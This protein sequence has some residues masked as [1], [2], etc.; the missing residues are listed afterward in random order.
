MGKKSR[1]GSGMNIPNHI[2]KSL[3]TIFGLKIL[4]FFDADPDPGWKNSD[5]I[6]DIRKSV[7]LLIDTDTLLFIMPVFSGWRA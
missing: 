5:P 1:S 7:T 2:S 3:G 4:N 6:P